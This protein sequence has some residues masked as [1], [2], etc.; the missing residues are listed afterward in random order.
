MNGWQCINHDNY[1]YTKKI[2]HLIVIEG[3]T[4][5]G[6]TGLSIELAKLFDTC[7]FS[8]DS[9]QFYKE[10]HIGTAKPKKS[11]QQGIPHHFIDSH[12]LSDEVTAAQFEK[13]ALEKLEREFETK[14]VVILTGGSGMFIDALCIGLDPIP[15]SIE[16]R[17]KINEEQ[18]NGGLEPL[19]NELQAKDPSYFDEVDQKNPMR[20]IRAIEVIRLTGK[21]YSDFRT[22]KPKPRPFMVHRFVINHSREK[23]Y[24]R[25][26]ERVDK[27]IAS[28][29]LEEV[30]S[31]IQYRELASLNTV[32]YKELFNYIDGNWELDYAIE[33][34]KQNTRNY[35]K[36][37]ITWFKK[38]PEAIW[39]DYSDT[40][41]MARLIESKLRKPSN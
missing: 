19:L 33:K 6:K 22:A 24:E 5:S 38:H 1:L 18:L 9:R 16:L 29:L 23:L 3:P 10:V 34:I 40:A 28:R 8:A 14:D 11:E 32:G 37:Q 25:I 21:P 4:A 12:S 13:E 26:N 2:K 41:T 17:N 20:V 31:V 27:M 30:K 39:I 7:V 15:S 36:R 35:A